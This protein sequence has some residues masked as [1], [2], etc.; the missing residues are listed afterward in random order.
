M[1]DLALSTISVPSFTIS[2]L[3]LLSSILESHPPGAIVLHVHFLNQVLELIAE[4]RE[5]EHHKLIVVGEDELPDVVRKGNVPVKIVW[6]AD[7]E[8]KGRQAGPLE[9]IATSACT[10]YFSCTYETAKRSAM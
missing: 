2:S 8:R 7:L 10:I 4:N 1:T 5:Y 3:S 9:S 6:L